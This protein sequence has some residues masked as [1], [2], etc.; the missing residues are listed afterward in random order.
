M[1]G[2]GLGE[3][4]SIDSRSSGSADSNGET[5]IVPAHLSCA[6][7]ANVNPS[8]VEIFGAQQGI[9][10]RVR[11]G[12]TKGGGVGM[13]LEELQT[14][15]G[16]GGKSSNVSAI[17]RSFEATGSAAGPG[18]MSEGS[19]RMAG[20]RGVSGHGGENRDS[21]SVMVRSLTGMWTSFSAAVRRFEVA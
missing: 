13:L 19:A 1:E 11:P 9:G 16:G 17:V 3:S 15:Y 2:G 21:W 20:G 8:V 18:S 14:S 7:S 5:G 12:G 6:H 10:P 4:S